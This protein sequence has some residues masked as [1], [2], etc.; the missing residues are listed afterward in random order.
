M[1]EYEVMITEAQWYSVVVTAESAEDAEKQAFALVRESGF[2]Q[3]EF[4]GS[5]VEQMAHVEEL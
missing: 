2:D 4:E 1:K 3:F 5:E